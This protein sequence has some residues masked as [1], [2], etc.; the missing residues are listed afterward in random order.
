MPA[1]QQILLLS[2]YPI[3]RTQRYIDW[4]QPQI[5]AEV[6]LQWHDEQ[7]IPVDYAA[8]YLAEKAVLT[9][10][11]DDQAQTAVLLSP[12]TPAMHA[13][14]L[15]L[16]QT[17]FKKVT[18]LAS[19]LQF[20]LK[21]VTLPFQIAAEFTP[22]SDQQLHSLSDFDTTSATHFSDIYAQSRV[23]QELKLKAAQLAQRSI[24]VLLLG[25]T[26]TGKELFAT[27]IHNS[28]PRADK[29]FIA[30]NCGSIPPELIDSELFGHEKGAF[31]GANVQ[32]KGIFEA[33]NGGTIFL[34]ELGELPLDAQVRLLRVFQE[35]KI[36]RVGGGA[37]IGVDVRLI[38]ATHRDLAQRVMEGKFREDL[39]Y[40]VS[41]GV[42]TLPPLRQREGDLL[43]LAERLLQRIAKEEQLESK[44]LSVE[45]TNIILSHPWPGNVRELENTLIR[46]T[47]WQR[48]EMITAEDLAQAILLRPQAQSSDGVLGRPL[49]DN[50]KVSQVLEEVERHYIERAWQESGQSKKGASKLL[51]YKDTNQ[52]L[53]K[54][55][56]RYGISEQ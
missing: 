51:G 2:N 12:G 42:L 9:P 30:L 54:R 44:K 48:G 7:M 13:V 23:M 6:V 3:E 11:I 49:D 39:F 45:A 50:F 22:L 25:E 29:P 14:W 15:L 10:L 20:G 17:R 19:S 53:T 1:L 28:S 24:P 46:A 4:L 36:R 56:A 40:R 31:T 52:T 27:A 34:D 26:G 55:M 33:A 8:I 5:D 35:K 41:I 21:Q 37:E 38:A 18:L 47:L 43:Y 16:T 32:K